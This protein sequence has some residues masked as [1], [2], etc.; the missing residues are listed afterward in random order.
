[1]GDQQGPIE[2]G[3]RI[4]VRLVAGALAAVAIVLF[5]VQ[6]TASVQVRFLWFEGGFP[7]FLLLL[8]TIA[9]TL[10]FALGA[11]WLMRRRST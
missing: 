9:L 10:I 11:N 3:R 4:N 2:T 7:L 6:N 5:V 8:I 1:M